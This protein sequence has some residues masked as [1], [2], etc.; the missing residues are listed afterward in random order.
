MMTTPGTDQSPTRLESSFMLAYALH[1]EVGLMRKIM[2]TLKHLRLLRQKERLNARLAKETAIRN[3][4]FKTFKTLRQYYNKHGGHQESNRQAQILSNYIIR[5][6]YLQLWLW[7][8]HKDVSDRTK[9][10][11]MRARIKERL[12][13][14]IFEEW[15]SRSLAH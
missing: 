12:K 8:L 2:M 6:K 7:R 3:L 1:Y 5:R 10:Q 11:H 9:V 15:Q 13:I 4:K 14:A